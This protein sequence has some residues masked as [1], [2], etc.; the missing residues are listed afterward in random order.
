MHKHRDGS[1]SLLGKTKNKQ[2]TANK[3]T[4]ISAFVS[5]LS[6]LSASRCGQRS[7]GLMALMRSGRLCLIT[8]LYGF[9]LKTSACSTAAIW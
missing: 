9:D 4:S 6:T 5:L 1:K 7:D 2:K 8:S 3:Q